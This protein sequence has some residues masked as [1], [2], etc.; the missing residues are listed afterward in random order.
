MFAGLDG[1]DPIVVM[2]LEDK[3]I[4]PIG[5]ECVRLMASADYRVMHK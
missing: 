1:N 5:G 3:E 4:L 2:Q